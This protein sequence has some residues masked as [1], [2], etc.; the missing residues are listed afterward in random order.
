MIAKI[1]QSPVALA[2]YPHRRIPVAT[3]RERCQAFGLSFLKDVAQKS[4]ARDACSL[5][6]AA[7]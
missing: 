3:P 2:A 4:D 6:R 7:M 5:E 1:E